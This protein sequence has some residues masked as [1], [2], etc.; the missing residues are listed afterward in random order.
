MVV[1]ANYQ[2]LIHV[3][4]D[5]VLWFGWFY[6]FLSTLVQY[7]VAAGFTVCRCTLHTYT[8]TRKSSFVVFKSPIAF[9]KRGKEPYD[10]FKR[11]TVFM[12]SCRCASKA[13]CVSQRLRCLRELRYHT[14]IIRRV[15]I[16]AHGVLPIY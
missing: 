1:E 9:K 5:N 6:R 11:C 12:L 10:K 14:F 16:A 13:I 7:A 8:P 15:V 2:I 4:H 3:E